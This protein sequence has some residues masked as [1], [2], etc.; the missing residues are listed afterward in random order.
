M[1]I[2]QSD[3]AFPQGVNQRRDCPSHIK[4]MKQEIFDCFKNC[5]GE[6][7]STDEEL[8]FCKGLI[9]PFV[10]MRILSATSSGASYVISTGSSLTTLSDGY[11]FCIQADAANQAS[12]TIT[13]DSVSAVSLVYS[14]GS[15]VDASF[16]PADAIFEVIYDSSANEFQLLK[17]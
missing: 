5:T 2:K 15:A 10:W 16:I 7:T 3:T 12:Q 9:N 13:V 1:S 6:V 8:S 11:R 17:I 4:G 14:N